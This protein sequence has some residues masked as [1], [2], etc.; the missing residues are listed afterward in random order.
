SGGRGQKTKR[1]ALTQRRPPRKPQRLL[2]RDP[3]EEWAGGTQKGRVQQCSA[4]SRRTEPA[5]AMATKAE[6]TAQTARGV[7]GPAQS[8]PDARSRR[9]KGL[10]NFFPWSSWT[11]ESLQPLTCRQ[12]AAFQDVFRL[13]SSSLTSTVDMRSIKV[14][15]HNAGIQLS[16]QE[17]CE[18]LRQADLDGD[19][20][21]SFKDFLGVLTDDHRLAQCM[22]QVRSSRVHDPQGLQTLFLEM[23][24]KLLTQGLVPPKTGQEVMSYYF[25]KQRTLRGSPGWKGGSRGQGRPARSREGP[26][27][28]CQAAR[29]T[30]LSSAELARSLHR[31]HQAGARSPY[32]QI[33]K[34]AGRTRPERR[35]PGGTPRP[36]VRL[37]KRSQLSRPKLGSDLGPL[38]Q[39]ESRAP[40]GPR[41]QLPEHRQPWKLAPSP[42]TLAQKQPLS[43]SP[44]CVRRPAVNSW[45]K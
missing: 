38:C 16:P 39:G 43:P 14:A 31:L 28:F 7:R 42:P 33:P 44:T 23:L 2:T 29:L 13:F 41:G 6:R 19:G 21:V 32:S 22:G 27:F 15:L 5:E 3:G 37:P 26:N 30:G 35:T 10:P 9:C 45:H 4:L 24:F 40:A 34:L 17:M 8:G 11:D 36:D 1:S 18:A 12:L 20:I 25:K